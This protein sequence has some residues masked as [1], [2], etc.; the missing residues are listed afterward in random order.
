TE[1]IYTTMPPSE[2]PP[3]SHL[4]LALPRFFASFFT[5]RHAAPV[6]ILVALGLGYWSRV[7]FGGQVLLPGEMLRGFAPFGSDAN[8]PWSIL[9]WDALAQYFSWRTLAAR[10]IHAGIIPLWNPHQFSGAPLLANGQSAIFYPL[11]LP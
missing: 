6:A 3:A 2:S 7:L 11:S 10:Q 1:D 5:S 9:Q 8:A 4:E